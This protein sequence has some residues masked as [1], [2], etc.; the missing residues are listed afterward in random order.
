MLGT[1]SCRVTK[2]TFASFCVLAQIGCR[3][4]KATKETDA[5]PA[6]SIS[7]AE[8]SAKPAALLSILAPFASAA[9]SSSITVDAP[10]APKAPKV[11]AVSGKTRIHCVTAT[12]EVGKE[13]CCHGSEEGVCVSTVKPGPDDETQLLAS[14]IDACNPRKLPLELDTIARCDESIDCSDTE[15]CCAQFLYG[16]TEAI[17]CVPIEQQYQS[18][19]EWHEVCVEGST[20]RAPGSVCVNGACQKQVTSLP[21]GGTNCTLPK[22]VCCLDE[23]RCGLASDCP[24]GGLHCAHNSDCLKGQFCEMS[25]LGTQC[26]GGVAWGNATIVCERDKDCRDVD[27][28]K[29][30]RCVPSK[31]PGIKNCDCESNSAA[32]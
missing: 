15:A 17:L 3:A 4:P 26:T 30:P 31:Y 1:M 10:K 6:S 14:Q 8:G 28:C 13:T 2:L 9:P 19:C 32:K 27:S 24:V 18:P 29:K 20:C 22:N 16:G 12:C 7:V 25:V 23:M 11:E 21:C 5:G